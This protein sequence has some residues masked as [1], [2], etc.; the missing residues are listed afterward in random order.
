MAITTFR[1]VESW[2]FLV[3][4]WLATS[5]IW[6]SQWW[7]ER[8]DVG[9]NSW[10]FGM[11]L[12]VPFSLEDANWLQYL[13]ESGEDAERYSLQET[14]RNAHYRDAA[15]EVEP[16]IRLVVDERP[17]WNPW[18]RPEA[19]DEP[20]L[21][22]VVR[23]SATQAYHGMGIMALRNRLRAV[24]EREGACIDAWQSCIPDFASR[25][26]RI[27]ADVRA[28]FSDR[29]VWQA[30]GRGLSRGEYAAR[31]PSNATRELPPPQTHDVSVGTDVDP[32]VL[33]SEAFD[34]AS[35]EVRARINRGEPAQT[36]IEACAEARAWMRERRR[37]HRGQNNAD[38]PRSDGERSNPALP[39]GFGGPND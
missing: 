16:A 32:S 20:W 29:R 6:L 22:A 5:A 7:I 3:E 33:L 15:M 24:L 17:S 30:E 28:P 1:Q 39:P 38:D 18:Y 23:Q 25:I 31:H 14:W 4:Q 37:R 34:A 35:R 2:R 26:V 9:N 19:R 12:V 13:R 11:T 10:V 21:M 36:H 27:S 8:A